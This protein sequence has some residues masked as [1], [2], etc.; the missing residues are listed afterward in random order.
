MRLRFLFSAIVLALFLTG[1][2]KYGGPPSVL[3]V[4]PAIDTIG[5]IVTIT[6][7]GFS[8]NAAENIVF[9]NDSVT[10][11]V[12]TATSTALTVYV[13]SQNTKNHITVKTNGKEWQT[14]EI[15][16]T[17]PKFLPQ[18]AAPG[19]PVKI[20]AGG[21]ENITDYEVSFNGTPA[22]PTGL[23]NAELTVTV[24]A[25]ASTGLVTV[26]YKGEPYTSLTKFIVAPIGEV[27]SFS[28]PDGFANPFGMAFDRNGQLFVADLQGGYIDAVDP[29]TGTVSK[30]AGNGTYNFSGGH[31]LLSAALY[32]ARN[33]AF[34]PD[35]VLYATD[36]WYGPIFKIA[37]DS[38]VSFVHYS[39][40]TGPEGIYIDQSGNLYITDAQ[41][42]KK[43]KPDG[44]VIILA[45]S[46]TQGVADGPAA[47]ATF[48]APTAIALDESNGNLYIADNNQIRLLSQG[49]ISRFAGGNGTNFLG[50]NG[51]NAG[52]GTLVGMV[53]DPRTGN[54]F[55]TD[56]TD[57]IVLMVSAAGD[58]TVVAGNPGQQGS[59]TGTGPA[60]L[61]EGPT[62]ITMDKN[63]VL[64]VSDGN[65]SNPA[66]RKIT[67]H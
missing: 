67:L 57:H 27:S 49:M 47:S 29:A 21:G 30:Y 23:F 32:G 10:G 5:G 25:G 59:Q 42:I 6:G 62:G 12:K 60:A 40:V 53:R 28:G 63:G 3:S 34:A 7:S 61:F 66:I 38:V 17:A 55:A 46:G 37:G 48:F 51:I 20:Y 26:I 2:Q 31:P 15:F 19:Y 44:S 22:R 64:Y 39:E 50:G 45:G 52:F 33:L 8:S 13:P 14:T 56:I 43:V 16:Q 41:Q 4:S 65:Y 24:P 36:T 1:C 18:S 11:I 9:F 58:V 35:G 54:I